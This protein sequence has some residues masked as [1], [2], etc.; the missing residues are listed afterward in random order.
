MCGIIG[1]VNLDRQQPANE[2]IARAMNDAITHRGPDDE[3]FYFNSNAAMGMRR[4]SIIDL[5]G[6]H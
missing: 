1:F 5:A 3:G 6:G 4:L 2:R